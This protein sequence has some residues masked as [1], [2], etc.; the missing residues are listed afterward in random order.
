M[1]S[2]GFMINVINNTG[3]ALQVESSN[4][5]NTGN[6]G[7]FDQTLTPNGGSTGPHYFEVASNDAYA[8]A[9]FNINVTALIGD[10]PNPS[11]PVFVVLMVDPSYNAQSG[12]VQ[13]MTFPLEIGGSAGS[14]IVAC[15]T[16]TGNGEWTQ[17]NI[18][19][20]EVP[21]ANLSA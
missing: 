4:Y 1:S 14:S 13:V 18:Y 17:G 10:V 5:Y 12:T 6:T 16:P 3:I 21:T 20:Y 2:T 8:V 11:Q 15:V 7:P 19:L 9:T